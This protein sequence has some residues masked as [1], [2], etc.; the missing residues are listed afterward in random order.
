MIDLRGIDA[1]KGISGN[2][3]FKF[4]GTHDFHD[5][6]GELRC[7]ELGSMVI[8]QG[9]VNGDG[10]ADFEILVMAASLAKGDFVL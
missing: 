4:I 5:V 6:K 3:K 2:Q 9:D 10:K 7:K 8:V 1:K